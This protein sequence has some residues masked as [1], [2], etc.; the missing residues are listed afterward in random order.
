MDEHDTLANPINRR[1][2]IGRASALALVV[3]ASATMLS[4]TANADTTIT[5]NQT[6]TNDGHYYSFW[7][8]GGGATSMSLRYGGNYSTSWTNCGNFT[9]GTGWSTGGRMS[10][11]YSGSFSLS[12][13]AYLSFYGWTTDPLVEYYITDNWGLIGPRK[14]HIWAQ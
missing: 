2:F 5:S 12:G 7:T 4:G 14:E 3:G 13:N 1:S 8:D 9:S 11:N 6:G 10:V